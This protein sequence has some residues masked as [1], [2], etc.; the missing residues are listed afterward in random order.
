MELS[1][2][3]WW[4]LARLA[5]LERNRTCYIRTALL[6]GRWEFMSENLRTVPNGMLQWEISRSLRAG[7]AVADRLRVR[8]QGSLVDTVQLSHV[9][10]STLSRKGLI[11]AL[12]YITRAGLRYFTENFDVYSAAYPEF[13]SAAPAAVGR[14][15]PARMSH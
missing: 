13:D 2:P 9:M 4:L 5:Y 14:W 7:L 3:E 8:P 15:A 12:T 1:G 6:D 10:T 11:P